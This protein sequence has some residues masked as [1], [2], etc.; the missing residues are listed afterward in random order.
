MLSSFRPVLSIDAD[1]ILSNEGVDFRLGDVLWLTFSDND[2]PLSDVDGANVL[3]NER[4]ALCGESLKEGDVLSS[5]FDALPIESVQGLVGEVGRV[6]SRAIKKAR[7]IAGVGVLARGGYGS[8]ILM[9]VSR[10]VWN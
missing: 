6:S 9:S 4:E 5:D 3:S 8:D 2:D 7:S 10:Q 1:E